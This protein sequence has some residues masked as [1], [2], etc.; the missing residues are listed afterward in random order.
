[1]AFT[2]RESLMW[3]VESGGSRAKSRQAEGGC[4][5]WVAMEKT[6]DFLG[7]KRRKH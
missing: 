5:F 1:M 4:L 6:W 7:G 2:L 3:E